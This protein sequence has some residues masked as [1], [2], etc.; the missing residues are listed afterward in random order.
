[1]TTSAKS[2]FLQEIIPAL[3]EKA[4]YFP[5][6]AI[7]DAVKARGLA[8]SG[9][10][11]K[12]YLSEAV[13]EGIVR[14][15]GRDWYSRL[16]DPVT[17]DTRP[18]AKLVRTAG[19]A[20]PLLDFTCWTT[21]QINP[22]MHHLLAHPVAFLHASADTL[23]SVGQKLGELGWDV[24]VNP[25]PTSGAKVIRPGEKMV[26]LRPAL[27]RQPKPSGRHAAIEHVLVDLLV[28]TDL[29]GL[30]DTSEA[31]MVVRSVLER[32]LVQLGSLLRYAE[33]RK[34]DIP[35]IAPVIQ[36]HSDAASDNR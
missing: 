10:S 23:E 32:H 22:W 2:I 33:S 26:V 35:A 31:E 34:L 13:R 1:V 7:R 5:L 11:L 9:G 27:G 16:G 17:L 3:G 25:P 20:F 28:E 18:L 24:A 12:V 36:R 29:L 30:M 15:A 14:S 6:S 4:A 21:V 8:L 19:K